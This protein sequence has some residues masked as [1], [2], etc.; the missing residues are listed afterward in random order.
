MVFA[1]FVFYPQDL[2]A[3]VNPLERLLRISSA[4]SPWL[5]GVVGVAMIAWT[6]VRVW[7]NRPG[8]RPDDERA[9]TLP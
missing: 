5:Y 1:Y 6:I 7:G 3:V 4:V 8:R 2:A 9:P